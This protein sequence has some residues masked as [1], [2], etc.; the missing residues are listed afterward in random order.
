MCLW[1]ARPSHAVHLVHY[2]SILFSSLR[3]AR[4]VSQLFSSHLISSHSIP[5]PFPFPFHSIQS[6]LNS[7]ASRARTTL[8]GLG[9]AVQTVPWSHCSFS[10]SG[11][12]RVECCHHCASFL[13]WFGSASFHKQWMWCRCS[14]PLE[15]HFWCS[16]CSFRSRSEQRK[17][18]EVEWCGVDEFSF[19]FLRCWW[20]VL[21][22]YFSLRACDRWW[23]CEAWCVRN[24]PFGFFYLVEWILLFESGLG[25]FICWVSDALCP[26]RH[27]MLHQGEE[28]IINTWQPL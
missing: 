18:Y 8:F 25:R 16:G 3:H 28:S 19:M 27:Q 26:L 4:I 23:W 22:I 11:R 17:S 24:S 20:F 2:S 13:I 10:W 5:L 1:R 7:T 21:F 15:P 9:M 14:V 6:P 12:I